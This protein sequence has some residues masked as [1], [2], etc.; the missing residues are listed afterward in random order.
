MKSRTTRRFRNAFEKL[1]EQIQAQAR[2]A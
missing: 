2:E 1:P